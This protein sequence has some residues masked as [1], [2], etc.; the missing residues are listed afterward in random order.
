MTFLLVLHF[1][2]VFMSDCAMITVRRKT[3]YDTI[4]W[5]GD[6]SRLNANHAGFANERTA[7]VTKNSK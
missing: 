2:F 5:D 1:T 4:V 3:S 7:F 6:C